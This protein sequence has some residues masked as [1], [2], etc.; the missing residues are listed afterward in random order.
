MGKIS[1]FLYVLSYT[2]YILRN[3]AWIAFVIITLW[4]LF[5]KSTCFAS[6]E[7]SLWP[8]PCPVPTEIHIPT[9]DDFYRESQ[10][11]RT[12]LQQLEDAEKDSRKA[13][14]ARERAREKE[15]KKKKEKEEKIR[16]REERK[17]E[18]QRRREERRREKEE[19]NSRKKR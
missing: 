5:F 2:Y 19:R 3:A 1:K 7:P 12:L 18:N 13:E 4:L 10:R 17:R 11:E 14:E 15:E 6:P 16:R 8:T 9:G